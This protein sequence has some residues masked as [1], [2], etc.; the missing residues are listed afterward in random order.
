MTPEQEAL[1]VLADDVAAALA[2]FSRTLR[3]G[4]A[5]AAV[6][7]EPGVE[8][9][10]GKRQRIVLELDGIDSREGLTAGV[11][12]EGIGVR[13]PNAYKV[14]DAMVSAGWLE[15]VPDAEPAH[16]RARR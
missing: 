14:L 16:W 5:P 7:V 12:A 6:E 13:Q 15:T 8:L 4:R 2:R 9:P 10:R 1:A 11:V 3:A